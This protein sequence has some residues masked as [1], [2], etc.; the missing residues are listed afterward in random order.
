MKMLVLIL[1]IF[2]IVCWVYFVQKAIEFFSFIQKELPR[3]TTELG[4]ITDELHQL[5]EGLKKD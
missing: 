3:L 2:A 4:K 1:G 5:R